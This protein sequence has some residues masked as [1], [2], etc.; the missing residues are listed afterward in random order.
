L[1][2]YTNTPPNASIGEKKNTNRG[3]TKPPMYLQEQTPYAKN[4]KY[5][6]HRNPQTNVQGRAPNVKKEY[7]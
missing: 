2:Y 1:H 6:E 4:E 3:F 7:K 5:E